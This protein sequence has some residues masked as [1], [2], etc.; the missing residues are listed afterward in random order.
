MRVLEASQTIAREPYISI[1]RSKGFTT[2]TDDTTT[3][4]E[5]EGMKGVVTTTTTATTTNTTTST[6][7]DSTTFFEPCREG[8]AVFIP[9]FATGGGADLK[10][11]EEENKGGGVS[12]WMVDTE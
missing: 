1:I 12:H 8:G 5:E 11:S 2:T 9:V 3:T 7:A 10:G 6:R 4:T